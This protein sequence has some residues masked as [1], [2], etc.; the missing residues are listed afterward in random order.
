MLVALVDDIRQRY[1]LVSP[2]TPPPARTLL[3]ILTDT[4]DQH[5]SRVAIDAPD[6][7]LTYSE[8]LSAGGS[9]AGRLRG[10][11]IGRG[12][13]V[14][15]RLPSGTAQLYVAIVGVL[16]AGAAYVPV[17]ADD[18]PARAAGIWTAAAVCE[19][20]EDHFDLT[21]PGS[22]DGVIACGIDDDAWVIFTSGSTGTPKGVAVSHRAAAAFV[23]AEA[24]L[25]TIGPEDRVLAGLS[26]A[27][28]ASCEEMWLAWRHGAA[29]V[30]ATRELVRAGAEFGPW[31]AERRISVISTVPTLAAMWDET[32]LAGVRLLIF[33]GEAPPT[34]LAW[35][36][37]AHREVWNTYGPT[38][39]TV[40]TTA[41]RL[42]HHEP[43][44][45]GWPLAGWDVA[46][47]NVAGEPVAVGDAGELVI[48]GVGLGRYLDPQ[49]DVERY[50]G[51]PALGW[52]RAYRSGDIVREALDGFHFVGRRDDQV[53]IGGRRLELGEV[54]AQL[55]A[56]PG[57]RGASAVVQ[58][59]AAGNKILVGYVV[60]ELAADEVRAQVAE[61]LPDGLVPLVV[62]LDVL[63]MTIAGKVDRRALPWPPPRAPQASDSSLG[64]TAAWLAE[65]W[66]RQ[67]G[68]T[69]TTAESDF[70][71]MGGTSLLAAKL[72]SVLRERFPSVAV[73][74]VYAYRRLG[75][76]AA[77]LD[78]LGEACGP[79]APA[80][81]RRPLRFGALQLVGVFFLLAIA[82]SQWI[83]AALVY[84]DLVRGPL[85]H[86]GWGWLIAGW[87]ALSSPLGRTGLVLL[88]KCVLL[89][90]LRPGR[91]SRYSWFACRVWFVQRLAEVCRLGRVAGTPWASRYARL[92]GADVGPG[93]RLRSVPPPT[94][95]VQIGA[96]ATLERDVDM[97][98]WWIDGQE[99]V[100]DEVRVGAG[101]SV[102]AHSV[103]MG[104][105][106]VGERAEIEPGSVVS[107]TVPEGERWSGR[108][109]HCVG[110]AGEGWP[111]ASPP[112]EP[113]ARFWRRM[114]AASFAFEG[115]LLLLAFAPAYL[116]FYLFD[117]PTPTLHGAII[118]PLA[119]AATITVLS[120]VT[121]AVL[122]ALTLR[123]VWRL[124][125]P[126]WHRDEG[127]L[128]WALWFSEDLKLGA[129]QV[130]FPIFESLYAG[131]WLRLMGIAV[132]RRT[133]LSTMHGLNRLVS[134][135]ELDHA[136]D[137][138][139]FCGVRAR[140]GWL[141]V[142]PIEIGSRT[143]LG[144]TSVLLD[145]TRIGD[146]GLVGVL[147]VAP[148]CAGNGTSWF[149]APALEL[150]RVRERTDPTRTTSPPR[151]LI[152]ARGATELVRIVLPN[153]VSVLIAIYVVLSLDSIGMHYGIAAMVASGPLVLLGGALAATAFT[154]LGKWIVIGRYRPSE[155]PLWSFFV[156]RDELVNS[157]G[158]RLAGEWLLRFALGTPVM[159]LYLR[160]LGS[161]V[162][163]GVWVETLAVTEYDVTELG[164]NSAIN[165]GAILETHLF[166]D[167]LLRIGPTSV[168]A[169]ATLG[170][171]AAV[172][173]DTKIGAGACIGAHSVVLRG[174]ELPPGT[175]WHGAPV[176]SM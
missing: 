98:G 26:V 142:E 78:Q 176:V 116:V 33:G 161:R 10:Q 79:G 113:H 158:E 160:A 175:R 32:A 115:L 60:G 57:V 14:G 141:R 97:H 34:E 122:V 73:A 58:T 30:P 137:D 163:S 81:A 75:A 123:L 103:L 53:K 111:T 89:R 85:P 109:A 45:I 68:P 69:V 105:A 88:A 39:A 82:S 52:A 167:R 134:F 114:F 132:G 61:Q 20:L 102:G 27:F 133:E 59:T 13:R 90:D 92:V 16:L 162:G 65:R 148:R 42:R 143:F 150:P 19:V 159:S 117:A 86:V 138:V 99:L 149:G 95:L 72:V 43:V 156:W 63:P 131:P 172:L 104:G 4:A 127:S 11:G 3:D 31:I 166:H 8:L 128:S 84:G 146:D 121:F 55:N 152:L 64:P 54:E 9:I 91:Y 21:S 154:V 125:R 28:D 5:G 118:V 71:A 1:A 157:M 12:D 155:H 44:T 136:T 108:P 46:V 151:W 87:L 140:A 94:S 18:P 83:I 6:A 38:E 129:D 107:G 70:F 56:V 37:A 41:A 110:Q 168:G 174:E 36:L 40:T 48:G 76:L 24:R 139:A 23:D 106:V 165:R 29:L 130:L 145:G 170:P 49:L 112:R 80:I 126:G 135:G 144:N 93:A 67:I 77:R 35:R 164:E 50:A 51:L 171:G 7:V 124:V 96:G 100:L 120:T 74:D 173:P 47:V 25:W 153:A 2:A 119:E 62:V 17:D 15:I 22:A 66:A 147:T 169:G 101:A